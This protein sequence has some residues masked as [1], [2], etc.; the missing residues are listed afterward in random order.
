MTLLAKLAGGFTNGL[1]IYRFPANSG[2]LRG[3]VLRPSPALAR[4]TSRYNRGW[5]PG[6]RRWKERHD[7][8][9]SSCLAMVKELNCSV[10]TPS[11]SKAVS[12]ERY[13]SPASNWLQ[14]QPFL[15]GQSVVV[16]ELGRRRPED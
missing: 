7:K 5:K 8:V 10:R 2:M 1:W 9:K 4:V 14:L 15:D 3:G 13:P 11:S 6:H 16:A 12:R